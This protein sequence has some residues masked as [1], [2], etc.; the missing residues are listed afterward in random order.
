MIHWQ[1]IPALSIY[2][3]HYEE[4]VTNPKEQLTSLLSFLG[5]QFEESSLAFYK[6]NSPVNTLSKHAIRQPINNTAVAKW[7]RYKTPLLKLLNES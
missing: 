3:I 6:R 4:L 1:T 5:C 7:E 2:N